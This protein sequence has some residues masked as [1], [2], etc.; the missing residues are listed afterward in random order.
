[1]VIKP[2]PASGGFFLQQLSLIRR[3]I[4]E[5]YGMHHQFKMM[6]ISLC[7]RDMRQFYWRASK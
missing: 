2:F 6:Q 7:V 4:F 5:C 3:F 1:M